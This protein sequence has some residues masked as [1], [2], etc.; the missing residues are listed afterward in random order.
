L[1][2]QL[3]N[4]ISNY[5]I[6]DYKLKNFGASSEI[7]FLTNN[8][9]NRL[10]VLNILNEFDRLKNEFT[11]KEKLKVQCFDVRITDNSVLQLKCNFIGSPW[12]T[13]IIGSKADVN[14]RTAGSTI[15]YAMSFL[16]FIEKH[17][18]S[19]FQVLEYPSVL[20]SDNTGT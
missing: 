6:E 15:S 12:L 3:A 10:R 13:G 2:D 16:N 19:R 20:T 4:E 18:R 8:K 7:H 17:P 11:G 9:I 5:F 14:D 1:K